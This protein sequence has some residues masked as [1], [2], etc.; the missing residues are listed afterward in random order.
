MANTITYSPGDVI[1]QM[2]VDLGIGTDSA[3]LLPWPVFVSSEPD[4]P[5]DCVTLYDTTGVIDGRSMID[6]RVWTHYGIQVRVRSMN[7]QAGWAKADEIWT[8][9]GKGVYDRR[10][11][12]G[13]VNFLVHSIN[14]IEDII[15]LGPELG[16]GGKGRRLFTINAVVG[17]LKTV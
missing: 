1:A 5:D 3:V 13:E 6:G 16:G 9:F 8:A 12:L 14:R 7:H 17:G 15:P 2:L 4:L 10:V 11:T